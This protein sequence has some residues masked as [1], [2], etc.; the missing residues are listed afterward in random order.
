M[1]HA[2][3]HIVLLGVFLLVFFYGLNAQYPLLGHDYF[4]YWP[5]ILE[6]KWHFLRQGLA[7]LRFA[8]HLCGGFPQYGNPQDLFYSLPQ[9]LSFFLDLW[10]A[11]Q[12]SI[13]ITLV[14]GYLGWV[15]FGKDALRLNPAWAHVLALVCTA[16]GFLFVHIAV[17]HLSYF[18][19][20][21]MSWLLWVLFH[22]ERETTWQLAGRC[23]IAAAVAGT[24]LYSGTYIAPF[25]VLPLILFLLPFDLFLAPE[26]LRPRTVTLLRRFVVFGAAILAIGA[27]KLVAVY[28]V[29]RVLPRTATLYEYIADQNMFVFAAKSLLIFPQLPHFFTLDPINRIHEESMFTSPTALLGII[30]LIV[31]TLRYRALHRWKKG[32]LLGWGLVITLLLTAL[33]HGTGILADS[34]HMLPL[35]SSIRVSERFLVILSLLFSIGGIWGLSLFFTDRTRAPL[36][37]SGLTIAAFI[38][39]YAPL[40]HSLEYTL[41]YDEIRAGITATPDPFKQSITR[42]DDLRGIK[43]SD[44]H[45]FFE[46]STGSRCY[47]PLQ[48]SAF[49]PLKDGPV[50]LAWD[51]ALNMYN[52]SC[53]PYGNENGC[54]PGDRIRMDDLSNLQEF[55]N[56]RK[57]TWKISTAQKVA[58]GVSILAL[59]GMAI[60]GSISLLQSLRKRIY[61]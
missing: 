45:Y 46:G 27:S 39:A 9:F 58:D 11:T 3:W 21:L 19:L 28:S 32:L 41:P 15:K 24:F 36:I 14:L 49:A 17:G 61:V 37:A 7:P 60:I 23:V 20:P 56:G 52:P 42:V 16:N 12:L 10:I 18:A 29:M 55:I 1:R 2:K 4:Y 47:E 40:I 38:A 13:L 34:L 59:L 6:G 31:V 53:I 43:V 48:S 22:R 44:F 33:A 54:A 30:A 26:G 5:R 8:A 50:N 25:I 57:T 51:G 35:F